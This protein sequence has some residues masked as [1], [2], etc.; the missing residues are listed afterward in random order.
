[1]QPVVRALS[2]LRLLSTTQ[3]GMTSSEIAGR[4]GLPAATVHR[5]VAV[6][7][8]EQFVTRSPANRRY[9]LGPAAGELNRVEQSRESPLITPHPSIRTAGEATG[10]TV[11][12]SGI[13]GDRVVCLAL[14]ESSHPLRLF[15]RI[16]QEMP[17]HAA[18][19]ARV[20]LAYRGMAD[21]RRMLESA[22]FMQFTRGT[23]R[24]V[25][26]VL[27]RLDVIRDREWDNCESE[28]EDNVWAVSVPVRGSTNAV[29]A[30]VTMAAPAHR[31][32]TADKRQGAYAAVKAAAAEM[33]TDLGWSPSVPGRGYEA[34]SVPGAQPTPSGTK[35]FGL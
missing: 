2:I 18:A 23:P 3:R 14:V 21:A 22:S 16:G 9:F 32:E 26:E 33:G 5:L 6:L 8:S 35:F 1:M 7:Q 34:G 28:L 24:T 19:S 12:L 15:V 20:L 25:D 30:S 4:L 10:E 31:M 11:F 27:S 17:L 13:V 29:A